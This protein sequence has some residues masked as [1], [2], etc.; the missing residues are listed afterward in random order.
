M[1]HRYG[2]RH[3]KLDG[4]LF[5]CPASDHGHEP[6]PLSAE[7]IADG[8]IQVARAC[9]QAAP[10]VWLEATC[11]GWNASP[12][13]LFS[14]NSLTGAYGDDSPRGRVPAPVYRESYTTARDFFNLQGAQW[15]ATPTVAQEVLGVVHQTPEPFLNDAV[16]TVMRGHG[17]LPVYLNPAYMNDARWRALADVL[18]WTRAH[19]S[20][21]Q[22]TD[23]LLPDSWRSGNCP[24]LT[25]DAVM[26]RE[27]YGYAH[28]RGDRGLVVIRNPWIVPRTVSLLLNLEPGA[29]NLSAVS[30]YPE[31]RVYGNNLHAGDTLPIPVAPYE[32]V[33]LSVGPGQRTAGRPPASGA[34]LHRIEATVS[35]Q[36][37]ARVEFEG[38]PE[39][40]GP[41][42]TGLLGE[43]VSGAA[44]RLKADVSV[45]APQA[46]LLVLLE[47]GT[48]TP[49]PVCR[50]ESNGQPLPVSWT[51]SDTGWAASGLPVPEHWLFARAPLA[52]G[53]SDI[54]VELLTGNQASK[55]SVWVWAC[56]PGSPGAAS[57]RGAL[58]EPELVS[59]DAAALL[60]PTDIGAAS[61]PVERRPRPVERIDGIFLDALEPVSVSQGWGILQ[62][63]RSVWG[64]PITLGDRRYLRGLGT[65]APARLVFD[66]AGQYRRF[67]SWVGAD[68]AT[69]PTITFEVWVDGAKRWESGLMQRDDDPKRVDLDMTG[70]NTLELVVGNGGN[71]INSDHADWADARLLR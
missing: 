52:S 29:R 39:P 15:L 11:F 58:P 54:A 64:K 53:R 68:Q 69:N 17:F 32:T 4:Y 70:A 50:V 56:R 8:L 49:S 19:A 67:Q 66:L 25:N 34:V 12:W 26:P 7:A 2:I 46:E 14:V 42:Y 65:H 51:G 30:L 61:L 60:P 62:K 22:E 47:G 16:M 18:Q 36:E 45:N 33:V 59:L 57:R 28:W 6:G 20:R 41:D 3:I 31:A 37:L 13:W 71:G 44:L 24:R 35:K 48:D 38:A 27:P 55:V 9:H 43:A 5:E 21:L 10:D 1:I 40:L 63:N 23:P